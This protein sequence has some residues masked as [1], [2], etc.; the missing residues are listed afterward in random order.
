M[1]RFLGIWHPQDFF[2]YNMILKEV[3]LVPLFRYDSASFWITS[4]FGG[5]K[6]HYKWHLPCV[7][8]FC[9]WCRAWQLGSFSFLYFWNSFFI[10][11]IVSSFWTV[12]KR[13]QTMRWRNHLSFMLPSHVYWLWL[14]RHGCSLFKIFACIHYCGTAIYKHI[15]VSLIL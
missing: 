14:F 11:L 13:E 15:L 12:L 6:K 3:R 1:N 9:I 7:E 2:L 8:N 10:S 4:S 5:E